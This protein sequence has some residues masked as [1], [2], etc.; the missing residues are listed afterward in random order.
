LLRRTQSRFSESRVEF[1]TAI[2]LDRNNP[3]AYADL[4]HTLMFLGQP[5]VCIPLI[6]RAIRLNPRDPFVGVR[7]MTLALCHLLLDHVDQ[8]ID[9]LRKAQAVSPRLWH[10]HFILAAALG[11]KG[12]LKEARAALAEAIKIKPEINSLARWRA[13]TPWASNP[14]YLALREQTLHDGLRRAGFPEE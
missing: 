11:L 5:E 1:K 3:S 4:G 12:E 6:E 9:L 10:A 8:A 14:Q 7:Y 2:A 13:S